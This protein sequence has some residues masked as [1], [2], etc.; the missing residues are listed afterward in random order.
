MS[1]RLDKTRQE[2][3][4]WLWK[5]K[6]LDQVNGLFG[7]LYPIMTMMVSYTLYT[8]VMKETLTRKL[9]CMTRITRCLLFGQLPRFFRV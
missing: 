7:F 9:T 1:D 2:E 8:L 5:L 3:L 6:L 4:L